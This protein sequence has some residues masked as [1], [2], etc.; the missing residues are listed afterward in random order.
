MYQLPSLEQ[1]ANEV[2]DMNGDY[3]HDPMDNVHVYNPDDI[4]GPMNSKPDESVDS[5]ISLPGSDISDGKQGHEGAVEAIA[6]PS[7]ERDDAQNQRPVTPITTTSPT[8][9]KNGVNDLPLFRPPALQLSESPEQ[10]RRQL[11]AQSP[12]AKL[13]RTSI[14]EAASQMG[15]KRAKFGGSFEE[16]MQ[17]PVL[18]DDAE[19][20]RVLQAENNG[21][22]RRTSL[23]G[24]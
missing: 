17:Q 13:K 11:P 23:V 8:L 7:V 19:F 6:Q 12:V 2:L 20:A 18:E 1:I 5:A 16:S 10:T 15:H 21:L 9:N 24:R 22:R 14:S 3:R 4:G